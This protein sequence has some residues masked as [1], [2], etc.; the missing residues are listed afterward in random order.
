MANYLIIGASSGI[1]L[2]LS[3]LLLS[4]G[5]SVWGTYHQHPLEAHSNLTPIALNVQEPTSGWESALPDVLDGVAYCPGSIK[6]LP[7][8]R[9]QAADFINDYSLQVLGAIRVLQTV[10]TRLKKSTHPAVVLFST[11]AVQT[12]MPFHSLVATHKGAV[13]GLT[14]ALAAE[15]APSIRVN[16]LAPSLTNTPLAAGLLNTEEKQQAAAQRHPLKR[17]AH[18][19]DMARSAYFLL[20]PESSFITGQILPVDGGLSSIR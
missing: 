8:G 20:T 7:F 10:F 13:E 14:R 1:G 12:G 18:A 9:I 5:H 4:E 6:L 16:A 11:V 15:W 3:N 2:A 17:I 19:T